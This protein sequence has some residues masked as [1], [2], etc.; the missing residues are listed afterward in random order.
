MDKDQKKELIDALVEFV[1]K[2][3]KDENASPAAIIA[4]PEIVK[5]LLDVT[6]ANLS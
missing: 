6:F 4:L 2:F 3:A 5:V 1:T